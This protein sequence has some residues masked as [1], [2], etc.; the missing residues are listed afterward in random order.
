MGDVMGD[1]N[2]KR[3]RVLGMDTSDG[4]T[5]IRAQGPLSELRT[6]ATGLRSIT[7]GRGTYTLEFDHYEEVPA[8]MLASVVAEAKKE[9]EAK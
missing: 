5:V 9:K 6:Y 4:T 1:L 8:H 3:C 7:Q 2:T